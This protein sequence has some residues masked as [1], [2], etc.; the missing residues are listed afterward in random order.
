MSE[1]QIFSQVMQT[2]TGQ[3]AFSVGFN[4]LQKLFLFSS[5]F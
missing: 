1:P 4:E 3:K 2:E 5:P